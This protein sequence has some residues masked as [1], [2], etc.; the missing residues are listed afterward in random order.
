[1][2][3]PRKPFLRPSQLPSRLSAPEPFTQSL[4][5]TPRQ[6]T[7]HYPPLPEVSHLVNQ[8]AN[9]CP[10]RPPISVE[11]HLADHFVQPS[12]YYLSNRPRNFL[13]K[14]ST[15]PQAN[16]RQD[17]ST[18]SAPCPPANYL[19]NTLQSHHASA[20][21]RFTHRHPD[22]SREIHRRDHRLSQTV[23]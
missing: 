19:R 7:E 14:H 5:H 8:P 18:D 17:L 15:R 3:A 4:C 6:S 23:K 13:H 21:Y 2:R 20:L 9:H 10:S 11:A 1:M 12:Q 22:T 16:F